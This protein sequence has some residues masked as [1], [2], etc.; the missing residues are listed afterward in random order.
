[1][2]PGERLPEVPR[3]SGL[4]FQMNSPGKVGPTARGR[5]QAEKSSERQVSAGANCWA[6]ESRHRPS[7][8]L[9]LQKPPGQRGGWRQQKCLSFLVVHTQTPKP[10]NFQTSGCD[11][12][13]PPPRPPGSRLVRL[14]LHLQPEEGLSLLGFSQS[15]NPACVL[16]LML[17]KPFP[18]S[19]CLFNTDLEL[20]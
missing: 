7:K 15:H 4:T 8:A 16:P 14:G 19:G 10:E 2:V 13:K 20:R 6:R 3:D 11:C 1:M 12:T 18:T 5:P 17:M 9:G